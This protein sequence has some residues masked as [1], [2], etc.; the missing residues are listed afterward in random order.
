MQEPRKAPG[1]RLGRNSKKGPAAADVTRSACFR[2]LPRCRLE[3]TKGSTRRIH[4]LRFHLWHPRL[5]GHFLSEIEIRGSGTG[6]QSGTAA[7]CQILDSP[8]NK[9]QNSALKSD[10]IHQM[11][12]DPH[13]PGYKARKVRAENVCHCGRSSNYCQRPFVEVTKRWKLRLALYF[14]QDR[15]CCIGS[16][17]HGDLRYSRHRVS[18]AIHRRSQ[19]SYNVDVGV[20]WN[21]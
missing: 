16:S 15:L 5:L 6:N 11:N 12:E 17:L 7:E 19:I 14:S 21:R 9:D 3:S 10:Q 1:A 20:V 18:L 13:Q 2:H 8:L 4:W